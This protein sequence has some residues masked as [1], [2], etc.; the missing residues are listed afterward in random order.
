[1]RVVRL[2]IPLQAMVP[3]LAVPSLSRST[4]GLTLYPGRTG[5][6][7]GVLLMAMSAI[8]GGLLAG[9]M[10]AAGPIL[11]AWV[12]GTAGGTMFIAAMTTTAFVKPICVRCRLLPIIREHEAIHLSGVASEGAVWRSM[13]TRHSVSSLSLEG[14]PAICPFCP[15]PR[16]LSKD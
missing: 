2:T 10:G 13:K 8:V 3:A 4:R 11:S 9:P 16:R 5:A 7:L 15:I 12:L 14:D 6:A 1:M